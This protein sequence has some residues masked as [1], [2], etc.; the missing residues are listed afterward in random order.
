MLQLGTNHVEVHAHVLQ[1]AAE[2]GIELVVEDRVHALVGPDHRHGRHGRH[3]GHRRHGW[4]YKRIA[5]EIHHSAGAV[6]VRG[7]RNLD[8]HVAD[9]AAGVHA[10]RHVVAGLELGDLAMQPLR[11]DAREISVPGVVTRHAKVYAVDRGNAIAF[12]DAGAGSRTRIRDAHHQH[13][14][15]IAAA[16]GAPDAEAEGRPVLALLLQLLRR[17]PEVQAVEQRIGIG[18]PD[19]HGLRA[20]ISIHLELHLV[21]RLVPGELAG[22]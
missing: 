14:E 6:Y 8:R 19:L 7:T 5:A 17:P 21:T 3:R 2:L 15:S 13:A 16:A 4:H 12:L 20:A 18:R 10:Q 9:T 11:F 22:G 1:L